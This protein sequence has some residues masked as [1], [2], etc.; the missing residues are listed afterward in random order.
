MVRERLEF[1][2]RGSGM[3]ADVRGANA[4]YLRGGHGQFLRSQC[5]ALGRCETSPGT[6]N[7]FVHATVANCYFRPTISYKKLSHPQTD[8]SSEAAV[9]CMGATTGGWRVGGVRTS[10]KFGWTPTSYVA[11]WWGSGGG[12]RLRQTGYT[13]LIFFWR[14]TVILQTKKL[15]P[16]L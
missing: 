3:G 7:C 14:R 15:D 4:L 1:K 13:F 8:R 5:G 16:Q 2:V 11:F 12:N 6:R 9:T 10:P